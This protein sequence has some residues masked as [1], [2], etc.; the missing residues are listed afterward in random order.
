MQ[1]Y[2]EKEIS[3]SHGERPVHLI[4]TMIPLIRTSRLSLTGGGELDAEADAGEDEFKGG[5]RWEEESPGGEALRESH[6]GPPQ[7]LDDETRLLPKRE[8]E[9]S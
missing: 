5:L 2:L 1:G 8:K 3:N 9:N 4:I 6:E 7:V